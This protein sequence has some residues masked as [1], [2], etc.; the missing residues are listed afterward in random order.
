MTHKYVRFAR[1]GFIVWRRTD[2]IWHS[3]IAKIVADKILSAGFVTFGN[4]P[5]CY[6]FSESLDVGSK[7]DD[8]DALAKQLRGE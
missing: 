4:E 1:V 3:T 7:P 6:G 5:Y 8:S 2:K